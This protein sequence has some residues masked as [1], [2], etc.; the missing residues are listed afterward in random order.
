M[1]EPVYLSP[2]ATGRATLQAVCDGGDLFA[3]PIELT[4][5]GATVSLTRP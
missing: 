1:N 3:A 4:S 2:S 5:G